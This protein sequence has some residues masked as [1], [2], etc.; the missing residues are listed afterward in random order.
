MD[1]ACISVFESK[2][3]PLRSVFR[4]YPTKFDQKKPIFFLTFLDLLRSRTLS[5]RQKDAAAAGWVK[6]HA[7]T[8]VCTTTT[9]AISLRTCY[10][11]RNR[12][13]SHYC[14]TVS[15]ELEGNY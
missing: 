9:V 6:Q 10:C 13:H 12:T 2:S 1:F 4:V 8:C 15:L 14:P 3:Y 7:K 11:H 5:R